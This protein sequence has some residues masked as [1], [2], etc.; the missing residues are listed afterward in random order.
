[1][2][3]DLENRDAACSQNAEELPQV[4]LAKLW[5]HVLQH[6][7]AEH[8]IDRTIP[9]KIEIFATVE[10]I[11]TSPGEPIQLLRGSNHRRCDVDTYDSIEMCT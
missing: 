10:N 11:P 3:W 9:Q 6:N 8:E 7:V 5:P 4:V 2:A 1:M